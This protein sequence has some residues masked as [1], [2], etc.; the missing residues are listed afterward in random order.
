MTIICT[1]PLTFVTT[2][3][4]IL[5]YLIHLLNVGSS[6]CIVCVLVFFLFIALPLQKHS[7]FALTG[8]EFIGLAS[9]LFKVPICYFRQKDTSTFSPEITKPSRNLPIRMHTRAS[10]CIKTKLYTGRDKQCWG[11]DG[12][13]GTVTVINLDTQSLGAH[14]LLRKAQGCPSFE[15]TRCEWNKRR[16]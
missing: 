9:A 6:L 5:F 8:I 12:A 11:S 4:F 14:L 13:N 10:C 7:C 2:Q 3:H 16:L 1:Q 15:S